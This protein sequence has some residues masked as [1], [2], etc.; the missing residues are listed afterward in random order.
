MDVTLNFL[1]AKYEA[2]EFI[3]RGAYGR[4]YK[5]TRAGTTTAVKILDELDPVSRTRF[6]GEVDILRR[7]DH[8]NIVKVLDAGETDGRHWYESEYANQGHFGVMAPYLFY[9]DP[10]RVKYFRQIC[11]G[12]RALHG[13]EPPIIHRDLKPRN[14][15][16]FEY[17]EPTRH[18]VLKIADFGIAAIAGD[19]SGLT[20]TGA[21]LGTAPYMAP[22]RVKNS[23]IKTPQS[24]IYSLG[25]TFLETCTGYKTPS[26][27]TMEL[28][29]E[30]LRPVVEKM[31][32]QRP[33]ERYQSVSAVL[34]VLDSFS[35]ARLMHGREFEEGESGGVVFHVNVGS[36]L[37]NA[38]AALVESN[39]DNVLDRLATFERKLDRLGDAHDH[40]ADAIMR[41]TGGVLA[42]MDEANRDA[43]LGLVQRFMN[44][45]EK[46][47]ERDYFSPVPDMWAHFL[48]DVFHFSSYRPTKSLCLEG[49]AKF[50]VRFGSPWTKNYLYLT[51]T[52]I[53]DPSYMEYLAACLREAG[54]EDVAG[55]LDG[56]P[57]ERTLDLDGLRVTLRGAG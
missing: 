15:L 35:F 14:I 13:L 48:A 26:P 30:I 51:I 42:V 50:L 49:L 18:T 6:E 12:V 54:R 40:E 21:A 57:E 37:D 9:S 7:I 28:V 27:E 39:A 17:L 10:D 4:V 41:V 55:L 43:L 52:R 2:V 5:C 44:T 16:C 8:G 34:E 38:F 11:L 32:R 25:I 22:E 45:A 24:D 36:E 46:T 53:E 1:R 33:G 56:V 3:D 23:K 47:S 31:I 20:T 29:P 19:A